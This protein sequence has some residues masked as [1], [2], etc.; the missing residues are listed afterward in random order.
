MRLKSLRDL[1]VEQLRDLY[2]AETQ[3]IKAL[4]KMAKKAIDPQLKASFEQ[5]LTETQVQRDNLE[6][7]FQLLNENP[8][9]HTCK[10]MKGIIE[11]AEDFLDEVDSDDVVDAGL[12][13]AAQRVEHY[14]IAG[15][16]TV[17]EFARELDEARIE[18]LLTK[19]LDEEKSTDRKLTEAAES[20][21]NQK[22]ET[23]DREPIRETS[24]RTRYRK[25]KS[26]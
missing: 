19:I 2:S 7:I 17:R 5:H 18:T 23:G 10:A 3:L 21:I 8:S 4:P 15:Y 20:G 25:I 16:G 26:I 9:G 6:R 11:E 22:A 12:I 24:F 14:E 13:A 1:F